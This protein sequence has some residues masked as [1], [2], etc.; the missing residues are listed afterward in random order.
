MMISWSSTLL[1]CFALLF[2]TTTADE[3]RI[4]NIK[5]GARG[6]HTFYPAEVS[7][8]N[9]GDTVSFQ[10]YPTG[11]SV[12]RAEYSDACVP[13]ES[14]GPGKQGFWSGPQ[15]VHD[16]THVRIAPPCRIPDTTHQLPDRNFSSLITISSSTTPTPYSSI[17]RQQ[18]RVHSITWLA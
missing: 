7:N 17:A 18:G 8:V 2:S 5:V 12:A 10:F 16:G 1:T 6:E 15:E 3:H 9:I 4:H 11:H 14:T 13:Y